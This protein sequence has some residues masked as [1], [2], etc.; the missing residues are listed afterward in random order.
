MNKTININL[1]G[2]FFH[3][4]ETAYQKLN[5]YLNSI[6]KSLSD[7]P[8]GRDEI[9]KDIESRISELLS[10]RIVDERQVVCDTDIDEIVVIMGQPEDYNVDEEIFSEDTSYS[11]K[12]K[13]SKKLYR[14]GDDKFLG[15]V[16]SG[17]AHYLSIE[18]IWSRIIW[19]ILAFGTGIGFLAYI[20]LWI[21]LPEARSTAEKLEMEGESVNIDNIEKKIREEFQ[22]VSDHVKK[23]ANDLSEK[24]SSA[25]F[26]KYKGKAKSGLQ[27]FLDTLGNVLI[28]LLKVFAKF[29]G[30][31]IVF[32]AAI[33]LISLIIGIFSWG[34]FEALGIHEEFFD[35]SPRFINTALPYWLIVSFVFMAVSIPFIVLFMLGLK[36][37]SNNS[38]SFGKVTGLTLLALWI[39][40][41]LGLIFSGIDISSRYSQSGINTSKHAIAIAATDTLKVSMVKFNS[42]YEYNNYRNGNSYKIVTDNNTKKLYSSNV[43]VD[44]RKSEDE[45][46][47]VKIRKSARGRTYDDAKD[48]AEKI[49]Y[50]F[51]LDGSHLQLDNY[52]LNNFPNGFFDQSID[53]LIYIPEGYTVYLDNSTRNYLD[54]VSNVQNIHDRS[55]TRHHYIMGLSELDC[56]DCDGAE[57]KSGNYTGN[58]NIKIDENSVNLEINSDGEKVEMK[59]DSSGVTIE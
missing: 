7:D 2:L 56:L 52:F 13:S 35:F 17:T 27:E 48:N 54:D 36:I 51:R 19:L 23:G 58:V 10:E 42:D 32:I 5:R 9:I 43:D 20:L 46:T 4:D 37:L 18:P 16:A 50:Q 47:Y 34:S 55:M 15:G 57:R 1:G 25:D 33:T 39:I 29:I 8:Q 45:S 11:R 22:N 3:I 49:E 6:R 14:D 28:T 24:I 31:L 12:R 30:A 59:L 44:I 26:K 38:K 40:A 21:L 41:V 53:V